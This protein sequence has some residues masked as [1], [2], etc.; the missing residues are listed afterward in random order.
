MFNFLFDLFKKTASFFLI[1]LLIFSF[2]FNFKILATNLEQEHTSSILNS[3][4]I[5]YSKLE[6]RITDSDIY[7]SSDKSYIIEDIING[8]AF[9]SAKNFTI[10]PKKSEDITGGII[11]GDLLISA[12]NVNIQSK[13]EDENFFDKSL[14]YGNVF[15][16]ADT[17]TMDSE[18]EIYGNLYVIAKNIIINKNAIIRGNV[19]ILADTATLNCNI[20]Q[21][22]YANCNFF[23]M[24]FDCFITRDLNLKGKEVILN[25]FVNKNSFINSK[26]ITL[27]KD[28]YNNNNFHSISNKITFSGEIIKNA[29]IES[30]KIIFKDRSENKNIVCLINGDLNYTSYEKLK[31]DEGIVLR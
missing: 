2:V 12:N 8:N 11:S 19:F 23:E 13:K 27:K 29:I 16:L 24:E 25:G 21:D 30:K 1:F 7:I 17:F 31:L 4:E 3:D 10:Y 18:C 28:F 26:V 22:L 15:A 6:K 20:G 5:F 9:I 14:I